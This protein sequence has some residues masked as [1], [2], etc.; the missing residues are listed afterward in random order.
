M[1]PTSDREAFIVGLYASCYD[2][3]EKMCYRLVDFDTTQADLVADCIQEAFL[4]AD[5]HW[6]KL[7]RHPNPQGWLVTTCQNR[8]KDAQRRERTRRYRAAWSLDEDKAL[9]LA[10]VDSALDSWVDRA[11]DQETVERVLRL[12]SPVEKQVMQGYFMENLSMEE[13]ADRGGS[14][15]SAVK[16]AIFRIRSKAREMRE[17][18][19]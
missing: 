11:E 17:K 2:L 5:R 9:Q 15:L 1:Q 7:M 14:T 4:S 13:V 19:P 16:S 8:L 12:L 10:D 3:L 6:R 18:K